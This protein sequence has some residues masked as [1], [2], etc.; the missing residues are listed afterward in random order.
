MFLLVKDDANPVVLI[1]KGGRDDGHRATLKVNMAEYELANAD[2]R[3][4]VSDSADGSGRE[5]I[6]GASVTWPDPA[7]LLDLNEMPGTPQTMSKIKPAAV[8]DS[9]C[10]ETLNAR[11]MM[12]RGTFVALGTQKGESA[13]IRWILGGET[14][15][16][17]LLSDQMQFHCPIDPARHYWVTIGQGEPIEL[18]HDPDGSVTA[19][20][21]NDDVV[22][23]KPLR[24][25]GGFELLDEFTTFY[26]LLDD[27]GGRAVPKRRIPPVWGVGPLRPI[28]GGSMIN[29]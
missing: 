6:T 12:P 16:R 26:D 13:S 23:N 24:Q 5:P 7:L 9:Q 2:V 15:R 19:T 1:P 22:S 10:P 3:F 14:R 25:T 18:P 20:I 8:S 21:S 17:Q 11:V 28:C 27:A 4:W 29:S